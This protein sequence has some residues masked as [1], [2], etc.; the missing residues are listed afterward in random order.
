[1]ISP[2]QLPEE[3]RNGIAQ[4]LRTTTSKYEEIANEF[5]V[6]KSSVYKLRK[7]LGI[8]RPSRAHNTDLAKQIAKLKAQGL[9]PTE[10]AKKLGV[11]TGY[12]SYHW[13]AKAKQHAARNGKIAPI[14]LGGV[15]PDVAEI[16]KL[17]A[18]GLG[19]TKIATQLNLRPSMVNYYFHKQSAAKSSENGDSQNGHHLDTKFL[20]GYGCAE[21]DRTIDGIAQRLGISSNLL[22]SGLSKFLGGSSLR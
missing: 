19:V 3:K 22:R 7:K 12:L 4:A 9:T 18:Q 20:V 15:R 1:M 8:E 13:Y 11:S 14:V 6:H 2:H 16:L 21:I 17:K 5:K 10:A